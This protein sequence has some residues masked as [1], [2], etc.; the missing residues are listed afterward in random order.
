MTT[1]SQDTKL[2]A[3]NAGRVLLKEIETGV[4]AQT[5]IKIPVELKVRK[6]TSKK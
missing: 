6:T 1:V 5:E 3:Q 2:I 4:P